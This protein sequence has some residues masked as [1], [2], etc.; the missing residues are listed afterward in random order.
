[1]PRQISYLITIFLLVSCGPNAP[2]ETPVPT[3]PSLE[4][5][6][7]V[8][9]PQLGSI[10]YAEMLAVAGVVEEIETFQLE[11]ETLDGVMLFDGEVRSANGQW[12]EEIVHGYHGEPIEAVI[13]A[14]PLDHRVTQAYHEVPILIASL[15]YRDEG[16]FG[17]VLF[18]SDQQSVGGDA[19]EVMGTASGIPENRLSIMLRHDEGLI[20]KQVITLNNPY[21]V[22]ERMWLANLLTNGYQ[23]E[24]FIDIAYTNNETETEQIL[25][26]ISI[27][28][29]SAAG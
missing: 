8:T 7:Q 26:T 21:Q 23:G 12:S 22:D 27:I 1:M 19:I 17:S 16:T 29:G 4:G 11:I 3:E 9:S 18:P 28:I 10:I 15:A 25:D 6:V 24:A 13:R 5:Q 20:D 2:A 14:K